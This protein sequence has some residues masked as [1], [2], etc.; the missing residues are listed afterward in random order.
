MARHDG[1]SPPARG[2]PLNGPGG[3]MTLR[4]SLPR[5]ATVIAAFAL[6]TSTA[7]AQSREQPRFEGLDR[8]GDGVISRA[9]WRGSDRSF[10]VHDLN[11]D[12]V[13]SRDEFRGAERQD[14]TAWTRESFD[15]LDRNQDGRLSR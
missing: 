3:I 1:A 4:L 8:N 14:D 11:G 9:E 2:L 10:R 15:A 13:I 7:A 12:G 6:C 5:A